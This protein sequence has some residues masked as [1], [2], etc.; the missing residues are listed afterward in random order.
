MS[1]SD[2]HHVAIDLGASGGRVALGRVADGRLAFEIVHRFPNRAVPLGRHLYWDMLGLWREIRDGLKRAAAQAPVASVGV[3][4]WGVDYALLDRDGLAIDM[5]HSYRDPRNEGGYAFAKRRV[6]RDAIYR[7]TGIQFLPLNTLPQ[8]MAARQ[9]APGL[10]DRAAHLLMLP[11]LIHH[12]LCGSLAGEHSNASTTQLY[13][14]VGRCWA[15]G[16]M[17]SLGLPRRIF[18]KLVEPGTVLG[19][20]LPEIAADL[21]LEA[22]LVVAP[23][24]HDTASA[25]AAV[26]AEGAGW[27]YVSSGTWCLVGV[28]RP[29]PV[30]SDAGLAGN[31]TNEQGVGGTTRLLRNATGLFLLQESMRAWGDPPITDV[32]A[33]AAQ[34]AAPTLFDVGDPRFL[35]AG[36]DMPER[37]AAWCCERGLAPPRS[38]AEIACSILHSL[39][40]G[41]ADCLD[42]VVSVSGESVSTVHVVGGGSRIALLNQAIADATG[43]NVLAGPVEATTAGNLLLQAEALGVMARG[44]TRAVMRASTDI[45]RFTPGAPAPTP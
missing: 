32:L 30:I 12:W 9:D 44:G 42:R 2:K 25:V 7:A 27:A 33:A 1:V 26:P 38:R 21:G 5:V 13:D 17:E 36:R 29:G 37:I 14:P 3:T 18:P 16:L 6:S 24:T 8:L 39:A 20:V 45:A 31:V 11:D 28:E 35:R 34:V 19:P 43:R 23:A 40:R 15:D 41:I 22:T 10:F 4:T